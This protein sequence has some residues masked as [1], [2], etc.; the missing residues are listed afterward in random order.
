MSLPSIT[1]MQL[2]CSN[3]QAVIRTICRT[4]QWSGV[5]ECDVNDWINF[6]FKSDDGRYLA[7]KILL[8]SLFYSEENLSQLL[9]RGVFDLILGRTANQRLV[10]L[11]EVF[12]IPS[13]NE[14]SI[15]A[16]LERT[17]F[18]PLLDKDKPS[19]SGNA[20][21]RLMT[22]RIGINAHNTEFHFKLTEERLSNYDRLIIID[23]CIGSGAQLDN[24]W[25]KVFLPLRNSGWLQ[26]HEIY[27]LSLVGYERQIQELQ[28]E[29]RL[30]GLQVVL[31]DK[32]DERN[33]VFSSDN[34]MWRS[35]E[36]LD[37]AIAFFAELEQKMGIP[38]LGYN[39]LDFSV[40]LHSSVPDWALPIFWTKRSDWRPLLTRKNSNN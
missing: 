25:N 31:C 2:Y 39:G 4:N 13:E 9:K 34:H 11:D 32:L 6:N 8:H 5:R 20:M 16:M 10:L 24:F 26:R 18:V 12:K 19:E 38:R 21:L 23:D 27:Y 17:I 7:T 36:E 30:P 3:K 22:G 28:F 29:G 1:D 40:F 33:R 15:K 14:S 35:Q 37:F